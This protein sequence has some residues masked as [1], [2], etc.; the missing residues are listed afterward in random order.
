MFDISNNFEQYNIYKKSIRLLIFIVTVFLILKYIPSEEIN[1][2][3]MIK[4]ICSVSVLFLGYELYY[5][6][7]RIELEK[8]KLD[9]V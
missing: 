1:R 2:E 8:D 6:S 5:P 7:V 4:I 9:Y 3:N